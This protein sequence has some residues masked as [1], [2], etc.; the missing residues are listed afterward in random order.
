MPDSVLTLKNVSKYFGPVTAADNINIAVGQ[1]EFF[2]LLG[3]S[4]SGKT[5]MLRIIAGLEKLDKGRI[6]IGG[7]DVTE[8]PPYRRGIGMV[9]QDF[10][11]FPHKTVSENIMFPLKMWSR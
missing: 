6:I 8:D 3:P 5:T 1:T 2:A 7:K 4:G 11:L 9:F 10:L